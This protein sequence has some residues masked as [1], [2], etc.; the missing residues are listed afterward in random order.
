MLKLMNEKSR[1]FPTCFVYI[2][3]CRC[4]VVT[5][6]LFLQRIC[7]DLNMKSSFG[8][9]LILLF[10]GFISS[11][12]VS[13]GEKDIDLTVDEVSCR[14]NK[15]LCDDWVPHGTICHFIFCRC[16]RIRLKR[17]FALT[18]KSRNITLI[19]NWRWCTFHQN[20]LDHKCS[21]RFFQRQ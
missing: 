20:V 9:F 13:I 14:P 15:S 16:L 18:K 2:Y 12:Q 3:I 8:I 1:W 5:E 10:V 11:A 6:N 19:S 7:K 21:N 17:H 4:S